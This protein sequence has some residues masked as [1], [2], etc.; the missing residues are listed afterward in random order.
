MTSSFAFPQLVQD[1]R[2][3]PGLVQHPGFMPSAVGAAK[4]Q[5]LVGIRIVAAGADVH[6]HLRHGILAV[7]LR[8]RIFS[9]GEGG[10]TLITYGG[11]SN[12][13]GTGNVTKVNTLEVRA[14]QDAGAVSSI[15]PL[16]WILRATWDDTVRG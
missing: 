12:I 5:R 3:A 2:A 11:V 15:G 10:A 14:G 8:L 6:L 16:T 1:Q 13:A 7:N 9:G 4:D